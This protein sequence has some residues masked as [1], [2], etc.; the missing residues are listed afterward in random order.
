MNEGKNDYKILGRYMTTE[1]LRELLADWQAHGYTDAA[2][3]VR[4]IK[5]AIA[6]LEG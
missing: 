4:V 3:Q 6:Y 2:Y 1:Q 5:K